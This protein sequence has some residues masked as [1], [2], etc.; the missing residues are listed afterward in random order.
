[1]GIA[2]RW[3]WIMVIG[4]VAFALGCSDTLMAQRSTT[5]PTDF[6]IKLQSAP[7]HQVNPL[8]QESIVI[9]ADGV[10]VLSARR[11][12][13]GELPERQISL[14]AVDVEA[15]FDAVERVG[16]FTLEGQ[17]KDPDI[18]DGDYALIEVT[19]N[20]KTHTVRTENIRVVDF[21]ILALTVNARVPFERQVIYNALLDND[22]KKVER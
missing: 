17:Y 15:I 14:S 18:I 10:A 13:D 8:Q 5:V 6:T 7:L 19:A 11:G 9:R 12:D 2:T 22:Y 4:V 3:R 21:D 16:F 20:G 1:M